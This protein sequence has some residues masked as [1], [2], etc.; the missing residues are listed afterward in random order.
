MRVRFVGYCEYRPNYKRI[1]FDC[2]QWT[3]V[4]HWRPEFVVNGHS[5]LPEG[6]QVSCDTLRGL[7]IKIP[8]FP[9][10]SHWVR[11]R[12]NYLCGVLDGIKREK[13]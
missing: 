4:P 8:D 1:P 5:L 10:Y 7:K 3:A 9:D 12:F 6:A 11:G 2:S 13:N